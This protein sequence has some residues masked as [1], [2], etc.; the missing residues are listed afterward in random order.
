MRGAGGWTS[1]PRTCDIVQHDSGRTRVDQYTAAV[2][3]RVDQG[4]GEELTEQRDVLDRIR[5][6]IRK[7]GV[8]PSRSELAKSLGLAFA[9]AVNYHLRALERRDW[10][11]I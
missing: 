2:S 5:E 6:H 10:I 1:A 11:P 9:S 3:R 4:C 8:P 7:W